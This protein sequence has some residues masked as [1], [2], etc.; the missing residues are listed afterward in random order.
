MRPTCLASKLS[1]LTPDTAIAELGADS[2]DIVEL[3]MAMEENFDLQI[4][5]DKADR[6]KTVGDAVRYIE[7]RRRGEPGG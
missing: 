6:I 2:I 5:E 7:Q 1:A 4:A 3:V